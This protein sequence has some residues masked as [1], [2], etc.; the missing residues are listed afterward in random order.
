MARRAHSNGVVAP[1]RGSRAHARTALPGTSGRLAPSVKASVVS[2]LVAGGALAVAGGGA[3]GLWSVAAPTANGTLT[4]GQVTTSV[5]LP[6]LSGD[7]YPGDW[8][9]STVEITDTGSVG[10]G[11]VTVT[12]TVDQSELAGSS[13][14][15]WWA[16]ACPGGS[17]TQS[18]SKTSE[19]F[20]CSTTWVPIGP[21]APSCF[22]SA[23]T[24]EGCLGGSSGWMAHYSSAPWDSDS[25]SAPAVAGS[26]SGSTETQESIETLDQSQVPSSVTLPTGTNSHVPVLVPSGGSLQVLLVEMLA[27]NS[28]NAAQG[29]SANMNWSF[30][31]GQRAGA[32]RQSTPS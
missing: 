29:L 9:A 8:A 30:T 24:P 14:M 15:L 27:P 22:G 5:T 25:A 3:Y 7:L 2:A 11:S 16:F 19:S 28:P 32:L 18:G 23:M 31:F 26:V 6:S 1:V 12:A 17:I 21:S 13:G 4:A 10:A 20:S